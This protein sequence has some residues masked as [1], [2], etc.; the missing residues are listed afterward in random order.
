MTSRSTNTSSPP[1][2][3]RTVVIFVT[4]IVAGAVGCLIAYWTW[5][6]V[7]RLPLTLEPSSGLASA[8]ASGAASPVAPWWWPTA[9]AGL[10]AMVL[11][12]VL[13]THARNLSLIGGSAAIVVVSILIFPV[14][15]LC[16][17]IAS[18][19]REGW[20]PIL[21]FI[22][23]MPQVLAEAVK[24]TFVNLMYGGLVTVP[25]AA[26]VGLLLAAFG[27]FV[28]WSLDAAGQLRQ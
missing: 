23:A 17:E 5:R 15:A 4:T 8:G 9:I 25:I 1:S 10:V 3:G 7:L 14:A 19:T 22:A 12:P 2:G 11:W 18:I 16:V 20:P 28:A 13:A 27:R 24:M 26:L 6:M 21:E